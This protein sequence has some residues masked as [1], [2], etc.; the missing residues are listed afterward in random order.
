MTAPV[1]STSAL[2]FRVAARCF[3]RSYLVGANFNTRGMQNVGLA[4]ALEPGLRALHQRDKARQQARRRALQHYNTH[5]YWTPLLVGIFLSVERDIARGVLPANMLHRVKTT[6]TY[7][8]SAVGDSF[9]GGGALVLFS[10]VLVLLVINGWT[11][12][13]WLW[14]T[15]CFVTLQIFKLATFV[16]GL[17][18]GIAFLNRLKKWNLINWGQRIKM[19]NAGLLALVWL[20]LWPMLGS[21]WEWAHWSVAVIVGAFCSMRLRMSR[22][23]LALAFFGYWAAWSLLAS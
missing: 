15:A 1:R 20:H 19:V 3:L 22:T 6:T 16:G 17:R 13:A 4:L 9:F 23:W 18:E 10:L 5:P 8:L 14:L 12:A 2:G 7:T 21:G 11:P